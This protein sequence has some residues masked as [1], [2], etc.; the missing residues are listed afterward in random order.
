MAAR[1]AAAVIGRRQI[2]QRAVTAT[3]PAEHHALALKN[4]NNV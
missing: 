2:L 1:L 4:C 3:V